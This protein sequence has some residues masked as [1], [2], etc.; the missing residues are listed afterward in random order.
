MI[1][2]IFA[3]LFSLNAGA[4]NVNPTTST[5]ALNTNFQVSTA[6]PTWVSYS[7]SAS[8]SATLLGGQ[9]HTFELRSDTAN[10]PTTVRVTTATSI[11]VALAIAIT[12][13]NGQTVQMAYLVPAGHFVRI[14]ATGTCTGVAVVSQ[15]ES[16]ITPQF[17]GVDF[18]TGIPYK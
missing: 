11:T 16:T 7:I 18:T 9:T 17:D 14:N 1:R 13:T 10:P 15:V 8:C 6:Y 2:L 4:V 12:V 5:R 3:L